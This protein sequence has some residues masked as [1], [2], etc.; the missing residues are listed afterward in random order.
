[1]KKIR[2]PAPCANS[3]VHRCLTENKDSAPYFASVGLGSGLGLVRSRS[4]PGS[5]A[6][7][8]ILFCHNSTHTIPCHNMVKIT[9]D[10]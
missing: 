5:F 9:Q 4:S 7:D 2:V 6:T 10:K 8:S 3:A 1:M